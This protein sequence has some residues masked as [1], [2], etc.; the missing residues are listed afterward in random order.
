MPKYRL[1]KPL[2][3]A[4]TVFEGPGPNVQKSYGQTAEVVL[5]LDKD[6]SVSVVV[7]LQT[8]K[9]CPEW[10]EEV[11]EAPAEAEQGDTPGS[12]PEGSN[13]ES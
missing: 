1:L 7:D 6:H 12:E 3:E 10:F 9:E 4:G 13:D 8:V 2:A 11:P 5:S